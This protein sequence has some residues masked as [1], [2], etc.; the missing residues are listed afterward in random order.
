MA[1]TSVTTPAQQAQEFF[2]SKGWT[3]AQAAGLVGNFQAESGVNLKPNAVGDG[4]TA[5]GIAQWK[6]NRQADFQAKY[7]FPIQ[8]ANLNQQLEFVNYELTE[9]KEQ[10]AG[11]RIRATTTAGEAAAVT[12]QYYE[13]SS[14]D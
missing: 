9:G 1:T 3:P 7:G 10:A 13:R 5:Y 12:D 11:A 2:V 6:P 14:G 4:G 8:Q